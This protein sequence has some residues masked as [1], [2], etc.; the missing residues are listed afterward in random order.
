MAAK[1][2]GII[3]GTPVWLEFCGWVDVYV[4]T[5]AVSGRRTVVFNVSH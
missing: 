3:I 2:R 1:M 4:V 5:V